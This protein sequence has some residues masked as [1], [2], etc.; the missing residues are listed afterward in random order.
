MLKK[1]HVGRGVL[2]ALA[3]MTRA[4]S[5]DCCI[6]LLNSADTHYPTTD[7][8]C[9][10]ARLISGLTS[11]VCYRVE[12]LAIWPSKASLL[13]IFDLAKPLGTSADLKEA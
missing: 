3:L 2:A 5:V 1:T 10:E 13:E 9:L 7:Y 11:N 8:E 12:A 6:Q 4:A